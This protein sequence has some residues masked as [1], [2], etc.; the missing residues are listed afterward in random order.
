MTA[1]RSL[2]MDAE[3]DLLKTSL[4]AEIFLNAFGRHPLQTLRAVFSSGFRRERMLAALLPL[5]RLRGDLLPVRA[6]A[7]TQIAAAAE[8]GRPVVLSSRSHPAALGEL[9]AARGLDGVA[10]VRNPL[11][12]PD[13]PA[14]PA[15]IPAARRGFALRDVLRAMRPHQWVKNVLLFLPVIAAHRFDAAAL[16]PVLWGIVAFS[17]A[18]SSIYIVNDLLDLDADRQHPTKCRR[19]FAAGRVPI[20]VGVATS[21]TLA[22]L[23]LGV[24]LSINP[25]FAGLI[26]LYV[27]LSLAYSFKLKRMRWID[28][29]TLAGL[30]TLRVV[31]GALAAQ[32][33][34]T[35][36]LLV[37]IYPVFLTLGAVKR[38]TELTLATS[39]VRLPGRGYGRPDR[40]DLLNVAGLGTVIALLSFFLYSFTEHALSL[41]PVQWLM[42]LTLLPIAGWLIRMV[43]LGYA[44]KQDYDPIVFAMRDRY[45]LSLLCVTLTIMFYAAGLIA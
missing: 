12:G 20:G 14:T 15:P 39:D 4:P 29:A 8:E 1:N 16:V 6:E 43:W 11:K 31:A 28:I 3:R 26:C 35:G 27:A 24:A 19:P 37:F 21:V 17:A 40:G 13:G 22:A 30:Y 44:G 33:M 36:Y 25:G 23:A 32:V 2:M 7:L 41:Y 38:L 34:V 18:A 5:T 42:W 10:V 9:V 45:G